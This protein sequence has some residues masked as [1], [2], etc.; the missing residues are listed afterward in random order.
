MEILGGGKP[1]SRVMGASTVR[2]RAVAIGGALA[3]AAIGG[4]ASCRWRR[5][6]PEVVAGTFPN[7]MGYLRFG[8][9][10]KSLL[11]IPDPSHTGHIEPGGGPDGDVP[12]SGY[13]AMM[14]RMSVVR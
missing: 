1:T 11:W 8:S 4:V 12:K 10:A 13:L 6:K 3:V 14:T 5:R 9:G 2:R 7:G